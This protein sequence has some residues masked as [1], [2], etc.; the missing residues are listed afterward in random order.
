MIIWISKYMIIP[1][2]VLPL[3]LLSCFAD[4]KLGINSTLV[5]LWDFLGTKSDIIAKIHGAFAS[6][7]CLIIF[8]MNSFLM[9]LLQSVFPLILTIF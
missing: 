4:I 7:Y 8:L 9:V 1:N 6:F 5:L 2:N 3:K